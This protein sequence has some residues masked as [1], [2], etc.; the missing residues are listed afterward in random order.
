M[1]VLTPMV[2]S[3]LSPL[4]LV[5]G[6]MEDM[7]FLEKWLKARMLSNRLRKWAVNQECL[8]VLSKSIN[9]ELSNRTNNNND[10]FIYLSMIQNE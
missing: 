6:L 9:V 7:L 2:A 8:D 10:L 3:S 4:L 1:L 5:H